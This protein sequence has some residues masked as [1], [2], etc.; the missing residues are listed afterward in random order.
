M[1]C[2]NCN[3]IGHRAENCWA[4]LVCEP[5]HMAHQGKARQG[6]GH[7]GSP[8]PSCGKF[9]AGRSEDWE[10][11]ESIARLARQGIMKGLPTP[12]LDRL[13]T[14]KNDPGFGSLNH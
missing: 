5:G 12:M 10:M 6:S 8:S 4:D 14:I 11:L 7:P 13:L 2:D 9:H 1:R 3:E